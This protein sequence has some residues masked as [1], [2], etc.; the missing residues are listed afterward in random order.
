MKTAANASRFPFGAIPA[1]TSEMTIDGAISRN[2]CQAR[3]ISEAAIAIELRN[4]AIVYAGRC[5]STVLGVALIGLHSG[6]FGD[7]RARVP[8]GGRAVGPREAREAPP[9]ARAAAV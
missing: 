2:G 7:R 8:A 3:P 1:A 9:P 6:H 5:W 4:P